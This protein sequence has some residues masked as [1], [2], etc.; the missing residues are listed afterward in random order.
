MTRSIRIAALAVAASIISMPVVFTDSVQAEPRSH[1]AVRTTNLTPFD[2]LPP[3]AA[4]EDG[5]VLDNGKWNTHD[6]TY[7]FTNSTSDLGATD[8]RDAIR[9][10]LSAWA[11]VTPLRFTEVNTTADLEFSW[12]TGDHGDGSAFDGIDGILAHAFFPPP[13]NP[14]P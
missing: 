3:A 5:Y 1:E 13:T 10:A 11:A 2:D 8:Q 7:R 4:G 9:R 12:R 6:L 14:N